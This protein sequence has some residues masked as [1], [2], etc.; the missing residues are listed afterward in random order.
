MCTVLKV[1]MFA[2]YCE[3]NEHIVP[4]AQRKGSY[5]INPKSLQHCERG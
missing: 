2:F 1:K 4:S 5:I 3:C